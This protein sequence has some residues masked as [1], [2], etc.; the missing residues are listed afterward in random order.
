M[1][2]WYV[3]T[4]NW[5]PSIPE[6]D[7]FLGVLNA[8]D[9][10]SVLRFVQLEDRKRAL[11]SRMLQRACV[12]KVCNCSDTAVSIQRTRGKKPFTTNA[13]PCDAPNFN[14]NVSHEARKGCC[15]A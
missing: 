5:Q 7:F 11:A 12:R 9:R 15:A 4:H 14:F 10:D 3:N 8:E 13:K 6:F 2:R 1:L